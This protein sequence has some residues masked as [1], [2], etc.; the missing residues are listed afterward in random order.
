M[1]Q[2]GKAAHLTH[3]RSHPSSQEPATGHSVEAVDEA[4]PE[5]IEVGMAAT[6]LK[7]SVA[8]SDTPVVVWLHSSGFLIVADCDCTQWF[9]LVY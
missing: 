1:S 6:G 2:R 3:G 4:V 8:Y 7:G 9:N 5:E